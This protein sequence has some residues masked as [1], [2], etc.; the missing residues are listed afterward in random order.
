MSSESKASKDAGWN[1]KG[2]FTKLVIILEGQEGNGPEM[3][4]AVS[5]GKTL[6][7]ETRQVA[8]T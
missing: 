3:V 5:V 1:P 8:A 2:T 4:A 7:V 6:K